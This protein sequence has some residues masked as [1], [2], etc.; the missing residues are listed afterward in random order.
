MNHSVPQL[1]R[2]Y[3]L[4]ML[5][6]LL[7]H[8]FAL[9]TSTFAFGTWKLRNAH[10]RAAYHVMLESM[11]DIPFQDRSTSTDAKHLNALFFEAAAASTQQ[12]CTLLGIKSIGVDY[13]LVRTGMARTI[14]YEPQPITTIVVSSNPNNNATA[15]EVAHQVVKYCASEQA[16][17]IIVGLPLYKNGTEAPQSNL[18]REFALQLAC[19]VMAQLGPHVPVYLWDE[20]YTSKEA[21]ARVRST[22]SP[23]NNQ[24]QRLHKQQLMLDADAACIILEHYYSENGKGAE[25]VIVPDDMKRVYLSAW[26]AQ[27]EEEAM[28]K[29]AE[30]DQRVSRT[31]RRQEAMER[32][33]KLEEELLTGKTLETNSNKKK[34]KKKRNPRGRW[35]VL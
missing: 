24:Q 2:H 1:R 30:L 28:K 11:S 26:K 6:L 7:L 3:D 31:Q 16:K 18:T 32:A 21:A 27:Q 9:F 12:S 25:Q 5:S 8:L 13:G 29:Q 35:T 33:R 22:M 34:K 17:R 14:G 20:R 15:L 19:V 10:G 4:A 23:H